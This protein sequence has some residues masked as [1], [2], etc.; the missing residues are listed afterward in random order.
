[1]QDIYLK[2]LSPDGTV[3]GTKWRAKKLGR[4]W[5]GPPHYAQWMRDA[6]FEHVVERIVQLPVNTLPK[7][8]KNKLMGAWFL[9]DILQ[10]IGAITPAVL[11]RN[12]MSMEEIK[13]LIADVIVDLRNKAIHGY[14]PL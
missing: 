6:G 13:A 9:E 8:Q 5:L 11:K 2:P 7:G 12:G 4:V 10:G 14:Y 3:D 1:M